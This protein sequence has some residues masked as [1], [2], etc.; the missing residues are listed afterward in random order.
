M[1]VG[2]VFGRFVWRGVNID[3]VTIHPS[4]GSE[5]NPTLKVWEHNRIAYASASVL[6]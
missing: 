5:I 4:R 6:S 2:G 3:D 1:E